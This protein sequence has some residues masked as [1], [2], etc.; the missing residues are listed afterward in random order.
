VRDYLETLDW[1]K[2][3]P[4]PSLPAQ[5]IEKTAAKYLEAFELLTGTALS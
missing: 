3:A 4:G 1:N 2:T 5:I